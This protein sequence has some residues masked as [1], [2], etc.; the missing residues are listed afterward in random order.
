[1]FVAIDFAGLRDYVKI[2]P[3]VRT[4]DDFIA[5]LLQSGF[6]SEEVTERCELEAELTN[7]GNIQITLS[8]RVEEDS[9][10]CNNASERLAASI[11]DPSSVR[12][13]DSQFVSIPEL[14]QF[15]SAAVTAENIAVAISVDEVVNTSVNGG[16][17]LTS[18]SFLM[19]LVL[20]TQAFILG[21][22]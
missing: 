4:L 21:L 12:S 16:V 14:L 11:N 3:R 20:V 8:A 15:A 6:I 13:D 22:H 18:L 7:T 10:F 19:L 17:A 1:M 9:A 2:N 5:V